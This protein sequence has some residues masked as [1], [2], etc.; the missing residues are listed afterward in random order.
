M[1][2]FVALALFCLCTLSPVSDPQTKPKKNQRLPYSD[3]DG[4]QV[5]SSVIDA[6]TAKLKNESVSIFHQT[7]SGDALGEIRAECA[8]RLPREFQSA[9]EDFDKKAKT[10]LLL[11][12]QFSIHKEYKLVETMVGVHTGIYSVSAVGFDENKTHAI[13][14]LQ[15]LVRPRGGVFVFLGGYKMLY[16]LRRTETGW[17]QAADAPECG[18]IY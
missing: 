10:I 2:S 3:T 7:V 14:L 8:S 4:Y 12:Q 6:R 9:L 5:L 18:Q 16:L 17:Q 1:K 13:V 15:Y 11:Q